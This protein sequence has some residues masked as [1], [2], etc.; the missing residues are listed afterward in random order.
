LATALVERSAT[1]LQEIIHNFSLDHFCSRKLQTS[2]VSHGG[3]SMVPTPTHASQGFLVG[4]FFLNLRKITDAVVEGE[5]LRI[6]SASRL[7]LDVTE[8]TAPL[9]QALREPQIAPAHGW[10]LLPPRAACSGQ[11][12]FLHGKHWQ[13]TAVHTQSPH[14]PAQLLWSFQ[15][16]GSF[17]FLSYA[18]QSSDVTLSTFVLCSQHGGFLAPTVWGWLLRSH[19]RQQRNPHSHT[20][21]ST[22]LPN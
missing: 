5:L 8:L 16:K 14:L 1:P 22:S 4:F 15:L 17:Q 13:Q 20:C 9:E 10:L 6:C 12:A 19:K 21:C 11:G 18:N 3:D 7:C 2:P